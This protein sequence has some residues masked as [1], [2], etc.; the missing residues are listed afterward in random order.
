MKKTIPYFL[1]AMIVAA[2][3]CTDQTREVKKE[4]HVEQPKVIIK[5][6]P[7]KPTSISVDKN[8]IKVET[9]KVDVKLGN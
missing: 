7:E 9:K 5:D 4:V 8:G 2:F 1:G 3:S 6:V